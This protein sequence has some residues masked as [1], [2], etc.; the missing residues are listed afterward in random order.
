MHPFTLEVADSAAA[1]IEAAAQDKPVRRKRFGYVIRFQLPPSLRP[2]ASRIP[3]PRT[4]AALETGSPA[5][6][7]AKASGIEAFLRSTNSVSAS[8]TPGS[9]AGAS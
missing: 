9:M 6:L 4:E 7:Q 1:A 5:S 8:S 3:R 2:K